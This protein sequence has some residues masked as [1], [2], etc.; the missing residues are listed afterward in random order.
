[1]HFVTSGVYKMVDQM[2]AEQSWGG[3]SCLNAVPMRTHVIETFLWILFLVGSYFYMNIPEIAKSFIRDAKSLNLAQLGVRKLSSNPRSELIRG[4][5]GRILCAVHFIL[6]SH[7]LTCKWN[8]RILIYV[9]QPCHLMLIFQFCAFFGSAEFSSAVAVFTI[10]PMVGAYLAIAFPDTSGLDQIY[11]VEAY[12]AEHVVITV[13]TP[14]FLLCRDGYST[15]LLQF[16]YIFLGVWLL[17]L[18]HWAVLEPVDLVTLVNVDFMLC[19]S[20]A[21]KQAFQ[22]ISQSLLW[23]SYRSTITVTVAL[24]GWPLSYIYGFLITFPGKLY[25]SDTGVKKLL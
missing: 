8:A 17:I 7:M 24:L 10:P 4:G 9:M 11:E 16:S 3:I 13:V 14:V 19:P 20:I 15:K 12:W 23:P 21:M 6:I 2:G 5:I 18:Y 22:M 1:M 25:M